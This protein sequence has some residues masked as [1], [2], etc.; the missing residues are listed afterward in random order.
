M[1]KYTITYTD[2]NDIE[3]TEDFFFHLTTPELIEM[4]L[5]SN[6]GYDKHV[7][8]I[9]KAESAKELIDTF[10][11]ILFKSYGEKS[12]DGRRF[13]KS[14]EISRNFSMTPAYTELFMKLAT[15]DVFAAQFM[16]GL[17]PK[18]FEE[19]VKKLEEANA[20]AMEKNA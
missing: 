4:Q 5:T 11:S 20:R 3:R 14:E 13:V 16:K 15:D 9:I 10:K 8:R 2:F 6:E 12:Q 1:F 17:I 18:N 7:E 19:D